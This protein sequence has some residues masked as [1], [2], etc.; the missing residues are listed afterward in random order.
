MA[1][2]HTS[3]AERLRQNT[4]KAPGSGCWLWAGAIRSKE[5]YGKITVNKIQTQAHRAAYEMAYGPIPDGMVIDHLCRNKMCVN[6]EHLE[7]V[8]SGE[9]S[10]RFMLSRTT[11][12]HGHHWSFENTRYDKRGRRCCRVCERARWHKRNTEALAAIAEVKNGG[13][14]D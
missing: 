9:N 13:A 6:P 14:H 7:A 5:G 8:T 2:Q 4:V 11:C 10:R 3:I 1:N 12:K